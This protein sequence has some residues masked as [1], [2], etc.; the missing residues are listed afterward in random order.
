MY[1]CLF[2]LINSIH[3]REFYILLSSTWH[4]AV[5]GSEVL[6]YAYKP[7]VIIWLIV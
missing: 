3:Y 4:F 5:S 6:S 2:S 7:G 1:V